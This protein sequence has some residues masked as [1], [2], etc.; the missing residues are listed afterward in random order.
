MDKTPAEIIIEKLGGHQAVAAMLG[1]DVSRVYR[2]TYPVE[3]GGTGGN[4][5][6][7]H[8]NALLIAARDKGIA[9]EPADFFLASSVETPPSSS[10]AA[11]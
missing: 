4:V 6:H 1:C 10:E 7:K 2:W 3:R 5:P 9:I 8:Q 11:A